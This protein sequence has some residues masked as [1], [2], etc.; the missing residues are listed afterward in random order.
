NTAK[1]QA[2]NIARPKAVNTAR[3]KA[4]KTTRPNSVVVN[5]IRGT[6]PISHTSRNL[7]EDMLPLGEEPK[8][9]KSLATLDESM[10]W[11]RRLGL[12][13]VDS[14]NMVAYLEK[15]EDNADF[16]EIVDFL[17]ASPLSNNRIIY[18]ERSSL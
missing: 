12:S 9:G 10:L 18:E 11:H 6:C 1:A 14:H 5:A 15:L 3:P 17:N 8:E 7:M 2:V 4:A 13:F 16:A